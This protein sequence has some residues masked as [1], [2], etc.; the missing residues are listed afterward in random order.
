V[1]GVLRLDLNWDYDRLHEQINNHKTIRQMLGHA[2]LFD[3]TQHHLQTLK[4]NVSLLTPEL[5]DEINKIV[6]TSGHAVIKENEMLRGRCD[7]FVVKTNVH[8]PTDINLLFD[9]M[10]KIIVLTARLGDA[11][12]A[13]EWRQYIY[14]IRQLK[15]L[16]RM[17]QLKKRGGGKTEQQ[18]EKRQK[19]MVK[20]HQQAVD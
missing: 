14:N 20:A 16:V 10:R 15:K 3:E 7:S 9:A 5:L 1:L 2:D 19:Q 18:Q 17:A 12:D 13:S 6:V 11:H 8:Y 4:D